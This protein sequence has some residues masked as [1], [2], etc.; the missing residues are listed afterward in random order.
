[1]K[2][3]FL[4]LAMM[5]VSALTFQLSAIS[6]EH[7][8]VASD[9]HM[10]SQTMTVNDFL[11]TD[12]KGYRTAEGKKL[13][14]TQ[15]LSFGLVQKSLA[16]KIRKGKLDGHTPMT[17]VA[18]SPNIYGLLSLIFSIAGLLGRYYGLAFII[19]GLILGIIGIRKD[20][21]PTM[22]IIGT[23]LSGAIL[24]GLVVNRGWYW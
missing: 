6:V 21:D 13:K 23:I 8:P 9:A 16:K 24:L 19:A 11:A 12:F 17:M 20:A 5:A 15:R 18:R 22:A 4:T 10:M 2:Q 3:I 7:P 14:W 1:M